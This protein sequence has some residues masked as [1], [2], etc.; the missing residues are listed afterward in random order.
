MISGTWYLYDIRTSA[1]SFFP[2]TQQ[3][4]AT[5]AYYY[6]VDAH[7]HHHNQ[8]QLP[9]PLATSLC[10]CWCSARGGGSGGA[11]L[12]DGCCGGLWYL[13]SVPATWYAAE[14]LC[15]RARM[16]D[17][18]SAE[19]KSSRAAIAVATTTSTEKV[20]SCTMPTC[21]VRRRCRTCRHREK[22][23]F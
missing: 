9:P 11:C 18:T 14:Y 16:N 23:A 4:T 5:S 10:W 8:K 21:D 15:I 13:L 3:H 1:W 6:S 22:L 19:N 17:T 20:M 12:E 2:V 7:H